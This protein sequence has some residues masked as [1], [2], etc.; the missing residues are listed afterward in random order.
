MSPRHRLAAKPWLEAEDFAEE[1][2]ITYPVPD[3]M[4]DVMKHCLT[5]AGINPEAP[6]GG[7]DGRDPAIGRERPRHCRTTVLDGRQLY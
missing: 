4:L 5:P 3:E 7:V 6:H 2:L 1:T